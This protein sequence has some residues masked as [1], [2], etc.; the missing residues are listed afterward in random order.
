MSQKNKIEAEKSS[1]T[2]DFLPSDGASCCAS[3]DTPITDEY[4]GPCICHAVGLG[5]QEDACPREKMA[6]MERALRQF[7][8]VTE[9]GDDGIT[10]MATIEGRVKFYERLRTVRTEAHGILSHNVQV[11]SAADSG[12][13]TN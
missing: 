9:T 10:Q 5:E 6:E 3:S 4:T 11:V 7:M 2:M 13:K 12:Q 1:P 8:A